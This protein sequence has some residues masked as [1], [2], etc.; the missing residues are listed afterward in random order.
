VNDLQATAERTLTAVETLSGRWHHAASRAD[1]TFVAGMRYGWA[2]AIAL[3]LG[4]SV[5]EVTQAL[6]D[7]DL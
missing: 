3:C 1:D 5:G 4:T 6:R 7:G 2:Q